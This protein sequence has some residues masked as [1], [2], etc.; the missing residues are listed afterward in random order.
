MSPASQI[1]GTLYELSRTENGRN[2]FLDLSGVQVLVVQRLE[3]ADHILRLNAVNYRKNMAWFRQGLGTSRFSEDGNPWEIRRD[4]TQ[5][6]FS[7]FDR[8]RTFALSEHHARIALGKMIDR[9]ATGASTIDIDVLREMTASVLVENFLDVKLVDTGLDL[10]VLAQIMERA[11][12]FS[13][14]PAGKA[15]AIYREHLAVLPALR[16]QALESMRYFRSEHMPLTP[17]LSDMKTADLDSANNFVLEQEL[18]SFLAAGIEASAAAVSWACYL[19]AANPKV[20]ENLRPLAHDL[21][22]DGNASWHSLSRLK[23]FGTFISETLRLFPPT[24]IITRLANGPD[25]LG[26]QDIAEEQSVIISFIG[27]QHDK[28]HRADPWRLDIGEQALKP[29]S[30]DFTAFSFG[31]R[32]C[33]GKQFALVEL[34]TFLSVFVAGARF[35]LTSMEPPRFRWRSQLLC[36]GGQPVR[37]LPC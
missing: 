3:E 24:P 34:A 5:S 20:Q 13:F 33:G 32:I 30:G 16:R 18:M 36:E 35:E 25:R 2:V 21:W 7:R 27:I 37:V 8:E 28:R 6:Y 19:L 31:P 17:M 10:A 11:S 29:A 26:D 23:P 22:R 4:L 1:C 12:E 14:V 15:G 9:S